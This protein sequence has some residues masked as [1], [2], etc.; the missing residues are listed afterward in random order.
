MI[1][2]WLRPKRERSDDQPEV[3]PSNPVW[4]MINP[5]IKL[6]RLMIIKGCLQVV[7][8]CLL[9]TWPD[10]TRWSVGHLSFLTNSVW[11]FGY[12]LV[13]CNKMIICC[14]DLLTYLVILTK[15]CG[16]D[17]DIFWCDATSDDTWDHLTYLVIPT[18]FCRPPLMIAQV[19]ELPF[20]PHGHGHWAT[21]SLINPPGVC[22]WCWWRWW[23]WWR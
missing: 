10:L 3:R 13:W 12:F 11:G 7:M 1:T 14:W 23:R 20:C 18:S 21:H 22:W 8:S 9:S 4:V 6:V 17:L 15:P 19:H 5:M 2:K 16:E